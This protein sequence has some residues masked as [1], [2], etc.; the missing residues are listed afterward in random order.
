VRGSASRAAGPHQGPEGGGAGE[1]RGEER[2]GGIEAAPAANAGRCPPGAS[3]AKARQWARTDPSSVLRASS[4]TGPPTAAGRAAERYLP[5]AGP[6]GAPVEGA[7]RGLG[8]GGRDLGHEKGLEEVEPLRPQP[9]RE[10]PLRS[11]RAKRLEVAPRRRPPLQ[12]AERHPSAPGCSENGSSSTL[13]SPR[14]RWR[15]RRSVSRPACST[16][17]SGRQMPASRHQAPLRCKAATGSSPSKRSRRE[18][19]EGSGANSKA[20]G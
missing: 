18:G 5:E 17:S 6:Q 16:S 1:A 15:R 9:G 13:P 2:G 12:E 4:T 8:T 3:S 10:G 20:V 19:R 7:A 11:M 14:S